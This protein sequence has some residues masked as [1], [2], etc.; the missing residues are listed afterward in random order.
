MTV[1]VGDPRHGTGAPTD[2]RNVDLAIERYGDLGRAYLD[3]MWLG[4]P[5]ADAFVADLD[6]I[7]RGRGTRMLRT[8]LAEGI[9][10]VADA[11]ASLVALFRQLDTVPDWVDLDRIDAGS[12]HV[13]RYNRQSGI[14]LGASS[15][16]IGYANTIA[17]RP[18]DMTGR[19][20]EN[21]GA[22][23]IEVG[24]W[25]R[26]ITS[27][28][29]LTR[30]SLG[31]ERTVRVRL[32]H[33]MVRHHLRQSPDWDSK[34]W[35]LAI[36]QA[37]LAYTLIEFCLVPL[38]GLEQIGAPYRP[39]EVTASYAR[40]RYVGH[41]L[42]IEENLLP[43]TEADQRRLEELHLLTRPPVEDFCRRLVLGINTEFLVP[44]IEQLLP[45]RPA[46][47]LRKAPGLVHGLERV[48]LGDEIADELGIPDSRSKHVIRRAG[49][50]LAA[51]NRQLDRSEHFRETRKRWGNRYADKQEARLRE[52]YGVAHDLV[53]ASPA[54]GREHPARV[55]QS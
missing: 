10:A 45:S 55:P 1:N 3:G 29:G 7:G 6:T 13:A 24:L 30:S 36:S 51:L 23:T 8:A 46:A 50:A 27:P 21:A 16:L 5:L 49:P 44:E 19:Y 33:A 42:G 18:L 47:V 2:V 11:P 43:V 25:L 54:G 20:I 14:V 35:G 40:W 12:R 48:F 9:G 37:H 17:S 22:R 34:A 32:I 31:F 26:E 52:Q 53:D 38:R 39:E 15:L 28:G 4:D 41:L